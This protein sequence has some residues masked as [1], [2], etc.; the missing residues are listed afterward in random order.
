MQTKE[1]SLFMLA[2]E[3]GSNPALGVGCQR[4]HSKSMSDC[5]SDNP[6]WKKTDSEITKKFIPKKNNS[7]LLCGIAHSSSQK[8]IEKVHMF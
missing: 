1:K 6:S 8:L 7:L 5:Q 2:H 3:E 4:H